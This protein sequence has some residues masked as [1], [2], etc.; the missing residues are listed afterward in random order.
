ME[1]V[2]NVQS[3]NPMCSCRPIVL[4]TT[5]LVRLYIG[6][7]YSC[8]HNSAHCSESVAVVNHQ[9]SWLRCVHRRCAGVAINGT[10]ALY[11]YYLHT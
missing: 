7:M 1:F 11:T 5:T 6:L 2:Q 3:H 8:L 10:R 9:L 4:A